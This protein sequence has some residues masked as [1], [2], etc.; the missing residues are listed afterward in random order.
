MTFF[1]DSLKFLFF[2]AF[3][4]FTFLDFFKDYL[5]IKPYYEMIKFEEYFRLCNKRTLINNK[6]FKKNPEPKISIITPIYNKKKTIHRY[7]NSIQNQ[8]FNDLEIVLIDDLSEDNSLNI[9]ESLTKEDERII[10]IKNKQRRGTLISR[11][12]G[13]YISKGEF[14]I[15]VDPDDLIS[16][17]ILKY[18]YSLAKKFNF[19]IIRFNLY[20][21]NYDLNLADIVKEIDNTLLRKPNIYLYL[22]YGFGRLLQLDYYITNKLINKKLFIKALNSINNFYLNQ[23]MIDCEDGLINFMLYKLCNSLFFTRKIGYYY[24]KSE[25]SITNDSGFKKRLKSNFLY[26]KFIFESTKNNNIEKTI[27]NYIFYEIYIRHSNSIIKLLK[28]IHNEKY[29][30]LKTIKLFKRNDFIPLSTKLI[31]E[32]LRRTILKETL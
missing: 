1:Q 21:G 27:A 30:Y 16:E 3:I 11:K 6:K 17:N 13:S 28:R 18:S 9:I 14:I 12:I 10:L 23:F 5:I 20:M 15:F 31:L 8:P 25:N 2:F 4:Y 19:E 32:N 24:V 7:L 26:F 22:F 29:F